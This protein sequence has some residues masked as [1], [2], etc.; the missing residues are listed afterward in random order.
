MDLRA[1]LLRGVY[2]YGSVLL[3]ILNHLA[4]TMR[5]FRATFG[6]SAACHRPRGKGS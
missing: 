5:Q 2:A 4:L 1:E 3:A 6:H